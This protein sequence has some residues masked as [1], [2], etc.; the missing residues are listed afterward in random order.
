LSQ[1]DAVRGGMID[2]ISFPEALIGKYQSYTQAD[3][4]T[5]RAAG[6]THAFADVQSGVTTYMQ[7][8]SET[9]N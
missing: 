3:L 7:W 8:L 5:L 4:S 6:C 1:E 9:T 2:Y